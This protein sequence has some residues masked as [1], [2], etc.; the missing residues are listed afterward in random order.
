[1]RAF[2]FDPATGNRHAN[3]NIREM[4]ISVPWEPDPVPSGAALS[5]RMANICL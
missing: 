3:R 4:T 5:N 1:M 2:A